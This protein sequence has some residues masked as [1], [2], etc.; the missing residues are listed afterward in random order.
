MKNRLSGVDSRDGIF[1]SPNDEKISSQVLFAKTSVKKKIR[2]VV[3]FFPKKLLPQFVICVRYK[4][5]DKL[6]GENNEI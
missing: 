1:V 6:N 3:R 5:L 4:Q 2:R